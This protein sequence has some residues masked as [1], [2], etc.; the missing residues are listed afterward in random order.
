MYSSSLN[1]KYVVKLSEDPNSFQACVTEQLR[2]SSVYWALTTLHLIDEF[3]NITT[4]NSAFSKETLLS[5]VLSCFHP[6]GGF[7]GNVG[8]DPH[9]LYTLSALQILFLLD[10]FNTLSL[11][12]IDLITNY[13]FSLQQPDGSF[14]GDKWMEIDSRFS[15]CAVASLALLGKLDKLDHELTTRF[16]L[17]CLNNDGG[18]GSNP[19]AESHGGQ[20]FCAI[21]TLS[22]LN[23]L[24]VL[25]QQQQDNLAW[26]LAERQDSVS[27]GLCGR[28]MKQSDVCYSWWIISALSILNRL[29]WIN[30]EK[31]VGYINA[32]Q[33]T[34]DGGISDRPGNVADMFHTFFGT[35]GLGLLGF[36]GVKSI[37]PT[38][39]LPLE[40]VE[41]FKLT[42]QIAIIEE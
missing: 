7:G 9:L 3:D 17:S 21:G 2:M 8:H 29:D 42:R 38:Y 5:F 15:Y 27:G 37:D 25:S 22:I 36:A 30:T 20:V 10:S 6:D 39:A 28:P 19:G 23:N 1:A 34:E 12:Q 16:L 24:D 13:I 4:S 32:C 40:I 14:S 26:W 41:K 35:A 33:D 18:F 31:L 11:E